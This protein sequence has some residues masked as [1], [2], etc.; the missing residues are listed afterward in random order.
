MTV[1][2]KPLKWVACGFDERGG[3][4]STHAAATKT[5]ARA[6]V[7][8]IML[9]WSVRGIL[10]FKCNRGLGLVRFFDAERCPDNLLQPMKYL[11]NRLAQA[12]YPGAVVKTP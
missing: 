3:L 5:A 7:K 11:K 9:P 6:A 1:N 12:I 2:G 10:C 8:A 4:V